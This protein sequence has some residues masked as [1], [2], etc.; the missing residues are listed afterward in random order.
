MSLSHSFALSNQKLNEFFLGRILSVSRTLLEFFFSRTQ[1]QQGHNA[2]GNEPH[3]NM[4]R[5]L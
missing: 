5:F 2:A 4:N 3:G 1:N